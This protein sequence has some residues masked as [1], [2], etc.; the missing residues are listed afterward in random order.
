MT[1]AT[2]LV[3]VLLTLLDVLTPADNLELP[4]GSQAEKAPAKKK[5]GGI[6]NKKKKIKAETYKVAVA[7]MFDCP[8]QS[9]LSHLHILT[10]C[11]LFNLN[12]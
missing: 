6:K 10:S 8:A 4:S 2:K 3:A 7:C 11:H 5:L 12:V 1:F 9:S